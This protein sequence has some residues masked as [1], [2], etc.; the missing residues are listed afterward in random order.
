MPMLGVPI[1][2]EC[3]TRSNPCRCK[4]VGPTAGFLAFVVAA[5]VEWP[6]GAL[7]YPFKHRK[8]R[9]IMGHP[10]SVVYPSVTNAIPI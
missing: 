2:V 5:V 3:G 1:C 6:L 7:V 4:I 10:V 9:K 8:G